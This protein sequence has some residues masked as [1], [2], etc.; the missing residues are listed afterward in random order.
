MIPISYKWAVIHNI[1]AQTP[2]VTLFLMK[3]KIKFA[4]E[5]V[6]LS[7]LNIDGIFSILPS[8]NFIDDRRVGDGMVK[9]QQQQ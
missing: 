7:N 5:T 9:K 1:F 4:S 3:K 6:K 8:H 2:C